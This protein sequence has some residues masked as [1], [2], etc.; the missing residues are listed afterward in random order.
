MDHCEGRRGGLPIASD[1]WIL[2]DLRPRSGQRLLG[3]DVQ[4]LAAA[5]HGADVQDEHNEG[6]VHHHNQD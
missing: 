4:A 2:L 5:I 1:E 3:P 6:T